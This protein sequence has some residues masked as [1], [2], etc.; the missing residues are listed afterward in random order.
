MHFYS[1]D[2]RVTKVLAG[3]IAVFALSACAGAMNGATPANA[4]MAVEGA[5]Y[6]SHAFP[7]ER[8]T[9]AKLANG[10]VDVTTLPTQDGGTVAVQGFPTSSGQTL[11]IVNGPTTPKGIKL[12]TG[13][14][15]VLYWVTLSVNKIATFSGTWQISLNNV[16]CKGRAT[17]AYYNQKWVAVDNAACGSNFPTFPNWTI[18]SPAKKYYVALYTPT[19]N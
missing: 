1:L 12:P 19:S 9:K 8:T 4:P 7:T 18:L 17:S 15:K 14:K 11:T 13:A 10:F 5:A 6:V 2:R 3:S 16:P